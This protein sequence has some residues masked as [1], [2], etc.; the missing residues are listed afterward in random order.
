MDTAVSLFFK[1]IEKCKF[2]IHRMKTLMIFKSHRKEINSVPINQIDSRFI[3]MV[4]SN[5]HI[6]QRRS[7]LAQHPTLEQTNLSVPQRSD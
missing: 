7:R 2:K 3:N 6:Y 5:L 4:I 1:V